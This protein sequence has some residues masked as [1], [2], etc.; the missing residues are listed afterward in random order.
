M[1]LVYCDIRISTLGHMTILDTHPRRCVFLLA[2]GARIVASLLVHTSTSLSVPFDSSPFA[3]DSWASYPY[4]TTVLERWASLQLRWDAFHFVHVAQKSYTYEYEYAFLPG[5]PVVM[6]LGALAFRWVGFTAWEATPSIS[7][8]LIGGYMGAVILE[9]SLQLYQYVIFNYA[10]PY[11]SF[12]QQHVQ[13]NFDANQV[14]SFCAPGCYL[15]SNRH[16]A[17]HLARNELLRTFLYILRSS[18][19]DFL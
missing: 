6:R 4:A 19:I 10:L 1:W 2:V 11:L 15:L 16:C 9:P 14:N 12:D 7:Q 17:C 3:L 8:L 13:I 18:W 5:I